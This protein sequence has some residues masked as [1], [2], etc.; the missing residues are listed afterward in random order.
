MAQ[1]ETLTQ[2]ARIVGKLEPL[3]QKG[4]GMP[5]QASDWNQLV[6]SMVELAKLVNLS[7]SNRADVLSARYAPVEHTHTGQVDLS[8][9][10]PPTRELV[11]GRGGVELKAAVDKVGQDVARLREELAALRAQLDKLQRQQ[12][13][14]ADRE[15]ARETSQDRILRQIEGMGAFERRLTEVNVRFDKLGPRMEEILKLRG[16]LQDDAGQPLDLRGLVQRVTKVERLEDN[17]KLSTGEVGRLRDVEREM[18]RLSDEVVR[19]PHLDRVINERLSTGLVLEGPAA[20]GLLK[21]AEER[22]KGRFEEL[23][24]RVTTVQSELG[25]TR[26]DLDVR[27]HLLNELTGRVDTVGALA[28]RVPELSTRLSGMTTELGTLRT[29]VGGQATQVS[30]LSTELGTLR[31]TL[32]S[33]ATQVS[34]LSTELATVKTALGGHAGR[35]QAVEQLSPRLETVERNAAALPVMEQRLAT[36]EGSTRA[37]QANIADLPTLRNR[38]TATESQLFNVSTRVTVTEKTGTQLTQR[39]DQL[40][41]LTSRVQ[42]LETTTAT[43]TTW[44]TTTTQK[45]TTIDESLTS[46]TEVRTQLSS[47]GTRLSTVET[48]VTRIPLNPVTPIRPG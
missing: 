12:D 39:V 26:E 10:T 17:L 33:Q 8:W 28:E 7:E 6:T 5:I 9:F 42:A 24:T 4:R 43:L 41:P 32:G 25:N 13:T 21:L 3:G 22:F 44:R 18:A 47:I 15:R 27:I 20:E 31:T 48:R 40:A 36:V 38:L 46:L 23:G 16:V 1:T 14:L 45:L 2:V 37:T 35:L 34:G 11:E 30:G 29:A 19:I